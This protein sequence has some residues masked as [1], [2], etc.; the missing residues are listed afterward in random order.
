MGPHVSAIVSTLNRPD[1][2][3][4]CVRTV[5]AN[6]DADFELVIVDQSDPSARRRAIVAVGNDPRLRWVACN[7]RGLSVSRNLGVSMTRAPVI[8]FTDDD[9]RVPPDWVTRIRAAFDADADLALLFGSVLLRHEDRVR[10]YAA[11][12]EPTETREFR[13][14]PPDMR[15]AW[16]V[17]ANMAIRRTVFDQIGLFDLSLGAGAP[18]FAGEEIDFTIRALARGLK[19]IHSPSISV[20]HLGVREGA[21]ASHLMR[22]YGVGLGATLTK[23]V[24]LGTPGAARL[25]VQWVALQSRLIVRNAIHGHKKPG[26]GLLGAVLWGAC[27]S[28]EKRLDKVHSVYVG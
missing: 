20:V 18:F 11:E 5:L 17:G 24:R 19:V 16:G 6:P 26:F 12:F 28:F 1:E 2:V 9:C 7:A 10:G 22:G 4:E 27:R 13:R 15:S 14:V 23:H 3:V 8:A 21:A 25:L